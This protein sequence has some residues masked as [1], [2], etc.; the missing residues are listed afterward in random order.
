M[1]RPDIAQ[2]YLER[3]RDHIQQGDK[4]NALILLK[5]AQSYIDDCA[6]QSIITL[7]APLRECII[8]L[9][10]DNPNYSNALILL[11]NAQSNL[12]IMIIQQF[13]EWIDL[14]RT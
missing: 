8:T 6:E 4:N 5:I 13:K 3:A 12:S 7:G 14:N 1:C 9:Q 11:D 2:D 10:K